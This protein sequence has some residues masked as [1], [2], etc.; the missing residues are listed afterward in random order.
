M[1]NKKVLE[2]ELKQG[3]YGGAGSAP[4]NQSQE[5]GFQ[6]LNINAEQDPNPKEKIPLSDL[7]S[8]VG[9]APTSNE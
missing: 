5:T 8:Q 9:P 1:E 3:T 2:H 6:I 7:K 4:S